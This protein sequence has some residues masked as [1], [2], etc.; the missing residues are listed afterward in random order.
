M[1]NRE[2]FFS[3]CVEGVQDANTIQLTLFQNAEKVKANFM[4]AIP[5]YLFG[6]LDL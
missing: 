6:A 4:G 3:T 2:T 1:K 5:P